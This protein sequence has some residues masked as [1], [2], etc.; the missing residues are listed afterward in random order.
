MIFPENMGLQSRVLDNM[1]GY[2]EDIV[3]PNRK[4]YYAFRALTHHGTPSN[5]TVPF[6]VELLRDSDEYKVMVSQYKY[7]NGKN[8]TYEKSAK[9]II[10]IVPNIERLLFDDIDELNKLN[11]KLDE[12]KMLTRGET[13]K[14][15]IRVTSK[16]TGKK[17]DINLNLKI[18][19]DTNSFTQN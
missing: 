4:Y 7:P 8:Y 11:Y 19:E 1:N 10:K 14:F 15:K 5:L 16:H 9:R 2:F 6:E 18:A 13:T 17:M 12:G 3:V